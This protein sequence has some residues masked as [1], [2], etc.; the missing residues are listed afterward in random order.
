MVHGGGEEA[1]YALLRTEWQ[2]QWGMLLLDGIRELHAIRT[3]RAGVLTCLG[4]EVFLTRHLERHGHVCDGKTLNVKGTQFVKKLT[5]KSLD[6]PSLGELARYWCQVRAARNSLL[7]KEVG[8]FEWTAPGES[9]P[10]QGECETLDGCASLCARVLRLI[11]GIQNM[12][13]PGTLAP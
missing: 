6:D 13:T 2:T 8:V 9:S 11:R 5:G 10:Q 7:H 3:R 12:P 1:P 4:F